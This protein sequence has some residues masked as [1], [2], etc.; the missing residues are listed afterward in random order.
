M[1]QD[2]I[3]DRVKQHRNLANLT[4]AQLAERMN[5][6]VHSVRAVERGRDLASPT[7]TAA[8]AAALSIPI[9]LLYG[10]PYY[11]SIEEEGPL[12]G[13][14]V[15]KTILAEG[16]FVRPLE[17][18]GEEQL[19][20]ELAQIELAIRND[21]T[22]R[23]MA[24]LPNMIR[25]LHGALHAATDDGQKQRHYAMMCEAYIAAEAACCRLG[26]TSLTALVLDRLDAAALHSDDPGYVVRSLMK[27][28]R[29]L[30]S[31]GAN[32]VAMNLVEQGLGLIVGDG[33]SAQVLRGYGHLRGAIVAARKLDLDLAQDHVAEARLIA[34]PLMHE[35][36]L[37]STMFGPGN[38][39]VHACTIELEAGDPG[40]AAR[41][42]AALH[43]PEDMAAPRA[44]AHWQSNARAWLLAG[45]T[46]E[47]MK[48]LNKARQVAPG[49]TKLAPEVR[50]TL[51]GIAAL[52]RRS[53]DGV[54]AFARWLHISV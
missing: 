16:A 33:E 42:G 39:E 15:L 34:E 32:D 50:E 43:L 24:M 10:T 44:G 36:D 27:R 2:R 48:A 19:Q 7:F 49:Q 9:E 47:A 26:Y 28:A 53:T 45:K 6:S 37:Y 35:S 29:L 8:A 21:K 17:P 30:M 41:E 13:L 54:G 12:E 20:A 11:E 52:E 3:G 5:Y 51:Q 1:A 14:A 38:V 40:K 22:R 4:Q 46:D 18:P 31:H 25:Q 23:A